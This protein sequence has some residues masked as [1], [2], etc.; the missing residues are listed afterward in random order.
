P[1]FGGH[2]MI[3]TGYDDNAI[4]VDDNGREHKG[5]FTLRN[6]WGEQFGDKGNF[7]MSYDYFKVLT[8]EA[9]RI[10]ALADNESEEESMTA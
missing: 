3:I 8:I 6:S 10:R 9:Q 7:Y 1:F 4:A 5:L 2:E